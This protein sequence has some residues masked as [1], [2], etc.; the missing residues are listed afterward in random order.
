VEC[1]SDNEGPSKAAGEVMTTRSRDVASRAI[2]TRERPD[3]IRLVGLGLVVVANV[4][5]C[6]L[7]LCTS[8]QTFSEFS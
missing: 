3:I 2:L 6:I 1:E 5:R 8:C 4:E 7:L